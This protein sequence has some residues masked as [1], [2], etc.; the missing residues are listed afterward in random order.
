MLRTHWDS[1]KIAS[2]LG[3]FLTLI[4]TAPFSNLI[5]LGVVPI[6]LHTC[7]A[8]GVAHHNE[9]RGIR[10]PS[11][12]FPAKFLV[13]LRKR[14][15]LRAILGHSKLSDPQNF[16]ARSTLTLYERR[17]KKIGVLPLKK[18]SFRSSNTQSQPKI[19]PRSLF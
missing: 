8:F 4:N 18:S 16:F 10:R 12:S 13:T 11:V 9:A 2:T 7:C 15:T 14:A 19:S 1:C 6:K 3:H 17:I 5:T